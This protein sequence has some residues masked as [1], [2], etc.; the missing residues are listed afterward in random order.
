AGQRTVPRDHAQLIAFQGE[1]WMI[2]GRGGTPLAET[3]RVTIYD[4]ASETWREGPA[5]NTARAGFAA[6]ANDSMIMIAGGE[7]LSTNPVRTINSAEA[8]LA[9]AT[10]WVSL[11]N[12]PSAVHGVP[13]ALHG[14][15][16]YLMGGSGVA[17]LAVNTSEVQVYR[18]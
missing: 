6:S 4:P 3:R 15:A 11:P 2:A 18:W 7:M 1:L 10:T 17:S 12:L 16:F 14:N 5:V 9:G 13:G 8:I